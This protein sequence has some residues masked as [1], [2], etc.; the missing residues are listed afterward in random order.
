MRVAA[1][2]SNRAIAGALVLSER[3]VA[4][5]VENILSK[6]GYSSRAQIAAWAVAKG[7]AAAEPPAR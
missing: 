4:K 2:L 7:L 3:T 1:G 6:L 5:H